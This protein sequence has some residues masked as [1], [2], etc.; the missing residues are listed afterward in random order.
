MYLVVVEN[1]NENFSE[2]VSRTKR[3]PFLAAKCNGV[4]LFSSVSVTLPFLFINI[5]IT[6]S[7][8]VQ[9]QNY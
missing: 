6:S 2:I 9:K 8:P 4:H 1:Y 7:Y 5:S 3:A